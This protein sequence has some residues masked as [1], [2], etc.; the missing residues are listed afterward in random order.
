MDQ[1]M[2][3]KQITGFYKTAFDSSLDAITT[4]QEQTEKM[5]NYSLAQSPWIPEQGKKFVTDWMKSYR[6]GSDD[7]MATANG[8]YEK[9]GTYFNTDKMYDAAEA[10]IK[11]KSVKHN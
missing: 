8:Q 10:T 9:L 11:G 3:T 7:F 4:L 2:L 1:K 6:K 5:V